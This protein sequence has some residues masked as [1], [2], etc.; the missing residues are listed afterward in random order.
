MGFRFLFKLALSN[1]K[2]EKKK[3][4]DNAAGVV[5]SVSDGIAHILG[6]QKVRTGELVNFS[7]GIKDDF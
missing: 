6:L 3:Q 2:L 4:Y 1:Y 7:G 5:L